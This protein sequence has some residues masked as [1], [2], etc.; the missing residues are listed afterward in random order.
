MDWAKLNPELFS[1]EANSVNLRQNRCFG[2]I[3]PARSAADNKPD[4]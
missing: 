1:G 3:S 2:E 4:A